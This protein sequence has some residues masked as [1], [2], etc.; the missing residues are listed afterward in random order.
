ME[1]IITL[2]KILG[3]PIQINI[4]WIIAFVLITWWFSTGVYPARVYGWTEINY[5]II[6]AVTSLVLFASVLIHELAHSF[7]ALSK[8][9]SIE[10]ITL[11]LFGG[12]SKI[13]GDSKKPSDEFYISFSG[14]LSS[15]VIG[16]IFILLNNLINLGSGIFSQNIRELIYV[17]AFMNILLAVFNL[18]PGF[19]MDGGRILRAIIWWF[20]GNKDMASRFVYVLGK[21]ISFLIVGWGIWNI[22][23]GDITG[24]IWTIL[25]GIFLYSSGRNEYMMNNVKNY[26]ENNTFFKFGTKKEH[27]ENSHIPVSMAYKPL[28]VSIEE[29]ISISELKSL[30]YLTTYRDIVPVTFE[31]KIQGFI[32]LRDLEKIDKDKITV[33]EFL[34]TQLF[35]SIQKDESCEMALNIM[36]QN[37][38]FALL[39][40]DGDKNLGSVIR[41]D[42]LDIY[43]STKK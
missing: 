37:K 22:F 15:L 8:G 9:H 1:E 38:L 36:D 23:L 41:E 3:I 16:V 11:F 27:Q 14:P 30:N 42:I 6:G 20:S 17:V 33:N 10:G 2:F 34:K 40:L 43:I 26:R 35:F 7:V 5:W 24:G 39:V 31:G 21:Y 12:V 18:I 13:V 25:I 28:S 32:G 29:D 19:P 4:T